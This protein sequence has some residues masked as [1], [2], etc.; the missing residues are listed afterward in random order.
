MLA[1][2]DVGRPYLSICQRG[3][4]FS[5]QGT[6]HNGF[7]LPAAI[8]AAYANP[9]KE[10]ICFSGD[11]SILMNIQELATLADLNLNLKII[12]L[13]N[14]QLGLVRQQQELFYDGNFYATK[15]RTKT[16][17]TGIARHFG[18]RS[19]NIE[20]GMLGSFR[21]EEYLKEKGPL[22]LNVHIDTEYNVYPMVPPGEENIKM[23]KEAACE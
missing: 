11:G 8:G 17:F 14:G 23:L 19:V 5:L 15:F 2:T 3:E 9:D 7:G 4:P 12:L 6:R 16:D 21:P 18:I 13:N 10:V 20:P 1:S 22:L